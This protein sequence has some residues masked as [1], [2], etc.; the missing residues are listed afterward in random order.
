MR[1][2]Y[3]MPQFLPAI[4]SETRTQQEPSFSSLLADSVPEELDFYPAILVG[5]NFLALRTD[6]DGGLRPAD[7]RARPP[8]GSAVAHRLGDA[9]EGVGVTL[10]AAGLA[11]SDV[12]LVGGGVMYGGDD[13]ALLFSLAQS[14][15][16]SVNLPPGVKVE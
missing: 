11:A 14:C 10:L 1:G 16:A 7:H 15:L 3:T 6:N 8:Q 4:S 5:V 13:I 9:S 12:A 2:W